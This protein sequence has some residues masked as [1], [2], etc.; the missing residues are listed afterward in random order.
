M[1]VELVTKTQGVGQMEGK[2]VDEMVVYQ[3]RVS[4]PNQQKINLRIFQDY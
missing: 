3:A 2:S 1:Y 4:S